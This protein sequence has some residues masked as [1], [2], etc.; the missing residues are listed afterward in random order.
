MSISHRAA[1]VP[2]EEND[3]AALYLAPTTEAPVTTLHA[4]EVEQFQ[5]RDG[6]VA[7]PEPL[8]AFM[9]VERLVPPA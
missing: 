9:G 8:Q 6:S 4:D 3:L 5:A 2:S 1:A 7:V